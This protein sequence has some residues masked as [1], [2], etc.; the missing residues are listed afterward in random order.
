MVGVGVAVAVAAG[1]AVGVG[2]SV[3]GGGAGVVV[4]SVPVVGG[5][6]ASAIVGDGL[7]AIGSPP[8]QAS[9]SA[10]IASQQQPSRPG[11]V[12]VAGR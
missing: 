12:M 1:S 5:A 8:V 4:A 9:A 3:A 6:S 7:E 2:V 10:A 11:T